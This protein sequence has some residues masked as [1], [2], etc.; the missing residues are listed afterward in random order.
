MIL[1]EGLHHFLNCEQGE[2]VAFGEP[3]QG[4]AAHHG[5]IGVHEFAQH[6]GRT[7]TRHARE[8][9]RAFGVAATAQESLAVGA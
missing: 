7:E 2:F 8:F 1:M 3:F 5:A 9:H 4:S 6:C